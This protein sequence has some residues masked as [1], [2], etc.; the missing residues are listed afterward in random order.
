MIAFYGRVSSQK[1]DVEKFDYYRDEYEKRTGEKIEKVLYEKI[2][3]TKTTIQERELWE[4][5]NDPE[6]KKIICPAVS[7]IGRSVPDAVDLLREL[8]NLRD[9]LEIY[10]MDKNLT[11]KKDMSPGDEYHFYDLINNAALEIHN[12]SEFIKMG[13]KRRKDKGLPLGRKKGTTKLSK[14]DIKK[15]FALLR[16]GHTNSDIARSLNINEATLYR[17]YKREEKEIV[18]SFGYTTDEYKW[19]FKSGEL[20]KK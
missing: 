19:D 4:L 1:Q 15:I 5:V 8:R 2:S 20:I 3:A 7:R 10:I 18:E 13:L 11:I 16:S 14:D 9:D 17:F 6:I 12:R